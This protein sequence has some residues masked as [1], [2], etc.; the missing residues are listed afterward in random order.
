MGKYILMV[1]S[2]AVG[3][4]DDAFNDWYDNVHLGEVLEVPGFTAAQRFRVKGDPV[5]GESG[6]RYLAVYELETDDPQASLDAL[7]AAVRSGG[8]NMTDT[9]N[10][11]DVS[12]V[13]FEP[14]GD[15]VVGAVAPLG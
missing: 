4:E 3:G 15:R 7:G 8:I 11:E 10:T 1:Q 2:N 12:A 6:H 13:L 14:I 5:A 9:I